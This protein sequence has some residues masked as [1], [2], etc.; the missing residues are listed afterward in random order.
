MVE[1]NNTFIVLIEILIKLVPPKSSNNMKIF[2]TLALSLIV[3]FN[4][5]AQITPTEKQALVDIYNQ[6]DGDSWTN[7][8]D[9]ETS[10][11]SWKGVIIL[12][13]KV[14]AL[15]LTDNNLTGK[16]PESI[17][18]LANL[19]VLNL[20]KNNIEGTI[21][22]SVTA[23]KGLKVLNISFNKLEGSLPTNLTDLAS[24][25]YLDLFFN[26]LSGELPSDIGA[27]TNL[28][29]L[30]IYSNNFYGQLPASIKDL[31]KLNNLQI[32]SNNFYGDL[33][34]GI[35]SID[36]LKKLSLFDNNF[37]G[38]FP[39]GLNTFNL[40]ELAYQ[41]NNFNNPSTAIAVSDD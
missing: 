38:D 39:A 27:L 8:W 26:N 13:N 6:T 41:N 1:K 29:R 7:S 18:D 35:A 28:R 11:K 36:S 16:L 22:Q 30:S 34:F 21:P 32:S 12:N 19:K 25:E 40:E 37:S 2:T 9:L 14:I 33:P 5:I 17:G 10:P 20:H 23:I 3:S 4:A 31:K 15:T 24:L